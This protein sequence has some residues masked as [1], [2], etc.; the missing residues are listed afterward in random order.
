MI[1]VTIVTRKTYRIVV[2]VPYFVLNCCGSLLSSHAFWKQ[3]KKWTKQDSKV[4]V[5]LP[6][7]L[8]KMTLKVL[9]SSLK[10]HKGLL[11]VDVNLKDNMKVKVKL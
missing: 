10:S 2:P 9:V 6:D 7:S 1:K 11:L 5:W 4:S 3:V 8:D